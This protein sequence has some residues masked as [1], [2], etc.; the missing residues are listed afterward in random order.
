MDLRS[1]FDEAAER[2]MAEHPDVQDGR[3]FASEG[4]KTGDRF[5][6]MVSKGALVLKLPEERVNELVAEGAAQFEVGHRRM[7]EWVSLQPRDARGCED[8]MREARA[9]VKT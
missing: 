4:L 3:M 5:F 9:F 2:L 1:Q 8:L 6:A 7:R